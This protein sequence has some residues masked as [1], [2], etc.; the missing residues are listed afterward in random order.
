[1]IK[2]SQDGRAARLVDSIASLLTRRTL[3]ALTNYA[4]GPDRLDGAG[5]KARSRVCDLIVI[6]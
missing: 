4:M 2:Q 5:S 6:L 1:M 3:A